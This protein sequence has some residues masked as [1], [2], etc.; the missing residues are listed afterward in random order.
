MVCE[1]KQ[2]IKIFGSSSSL[3]III[4]KRSETLHVLPDIKKKSQNIYFVSAI[5]WTHTKLNKDNKN[6]C[7][8]WARKY[9]A[10]TG[11]PEATVCFD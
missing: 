11:L 4:E 10:E 5:C 6:N 9:P 2:L 7:V 1:N 3:E 8:E